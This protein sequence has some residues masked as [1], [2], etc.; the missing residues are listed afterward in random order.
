[1]G[2]SG[3]YV[4]D[5]YVCVQNYVCNIIIFIISSMWLSGFLYCHMFVGVYI[6]V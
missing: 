5:S 2:D 4:F 1:M 3:V 6:I